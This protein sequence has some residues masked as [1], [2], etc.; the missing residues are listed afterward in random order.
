MTTQFQK[1]RRLDLFR[2]LENY[3]FLKGYECGPL[4]YE[5]FL[6]RKT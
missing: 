3:G 6:E 1:P 4:D 5:R 2:M